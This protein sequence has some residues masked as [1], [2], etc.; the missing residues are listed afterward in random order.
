MEDG[1]LICWL[2]KCFHEE[3]PQQTNTYQIYS[4][5]DS[6][7]KKEIAAAARYIFN[8]LSAVEQNV[9]NARAKLQG[10]S[11]GEFIIESIA[12]NT[13]RTFKIDFD[14][15]GRSGSGSGSGN[16]G[17][18]TEI[19]RE[20]AIATGIWGDITNYSFRG[21]TD[22]A[23]MNVKGMDVG[24]FFNDQGKVASAGILSDILNKDQLSQ[25]LDST[26]ISFGDQFIG[27][28]SDRIFWNK[29]SIIFLI[30]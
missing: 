21:T 26:Q 11:A 20:A 16:G 24:L 29:D 1:I 2:Y 10:Q 17:G 6:E 12:Y 30:N 15:N 18:D 25:I 14:K 5:F 7:A 28:K 19:P 3:C 23:R 13:D 4:T 9:L 8:S 27:D 22:E